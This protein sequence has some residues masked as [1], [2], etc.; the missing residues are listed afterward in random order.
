MERP[1]LAAAETAEEVDRCKR[2]WFWITRDMF[3][4]QPGTMTLTE[5]VRS[6][7]RWRASVSAAPG[8]EWRVKDD[9]VAVPLDCWYTIVDH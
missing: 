5:R 8:Q 4:Q 2:I 1:L 9:S 7:D 6:W 3:L